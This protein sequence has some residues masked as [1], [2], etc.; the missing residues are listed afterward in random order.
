MDIQLT[1][2]RSIRSAI[3]AAY[4]AARKNHEPTGINV[5]DLGSECDRA[6]FYT[7]R[8]VS[9]PETIEGRKLRLF[10]TGNIE[11]QRIVDDLVLIGCEVIGQ[12]EYVRFLGGHVRG[13]IDGE[14]MGV[15][16][17]P[18]VVHLIECKSSNDKNFKDL[19]KNGLEKSQPKHYGQCQIYMHGRGLPFALYFVVNKNNDDIY[20]ERIAHD[21]AYCERILERAGRIMIAHDPPPRISENQKIP[22]CLFCR[23]KVVCHDGDWPRFNCRTCVYGIPDLFG[24]DADW[25][26]GKYGHPLT[27][28][29]QETGCLSHLFLPGL[30]PGKQVDHG[31]DW[32]SYELP[33]GDLWVNGQQSA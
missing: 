28:E 25:S 31:E 24:D 4:E 1:P 17:D 9:P 21:E 30:V 23:H 19:Q 7:F 5:G 20:T 32:I 11:E 14:V 22:P 6:L 18:E 12:Q 29:E 16:D 15:P 10:E 8:H 33:N 27:R 3:F 2:P 26:C 13:K